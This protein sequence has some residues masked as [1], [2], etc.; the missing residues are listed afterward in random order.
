MKQEILPAVAA[1]IFDEN[2]YILLQK[3]KDVNKWCLIS[4]HVEFGETVEEAMRREIFE[5]TNTTAAIIRLIGVYSS[6]LSQTYYYPGK[7][8]QYVTSYFEA[9]LEQPIDNN[10]SNEETGELKFF[11]PGNL[12]PEMAQLNP[13]WLNDALDTRSMAF[14]R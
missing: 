11:Y 6:P 3:R 14:I 9:R 12:P 13:D 2:G 8:V 5:E 1:V 4:G 7:T 10:F